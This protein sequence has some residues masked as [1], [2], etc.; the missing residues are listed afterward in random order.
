MSGYK[1]LEAHIKSLSDEGVKGSNSMPGL[2]YSICWKS[3][4]TI[5]THAFPQLIVAAIVTNMEI[6]NKYMEHS[7]TSASKI[8][9]FFDVDEDAS[10]IPVVE[11]VSLECVM[12]EIDAL[13]TIRKEVERAAQ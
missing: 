13:N 11:P 3:G 12:A 4:V 7:A 8:G 1:L 6:A 9:F 10:I 5:T 2:A